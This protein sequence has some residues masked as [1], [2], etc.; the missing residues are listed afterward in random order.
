MGDRDDVALT[1]TVPELLE[2]CNTVQNVQTVIGQQGFSIRV[3]NNKE[4]L[5]ENSNQC[6]LFEAWHIRISA[7]ISFRNSIFS[8]IVE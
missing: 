6:P 5:G 3:K 8:Q 7:I 1:K 2:R 4:N